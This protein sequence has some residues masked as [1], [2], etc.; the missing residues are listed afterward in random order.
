MIILELP[1]ELENRLNIEA[2]RLGVTQRGFIQQAI[3]A[4]LGDVEDME[5]A[6]IAEERLNVQGKRYT[7]DE[8]EKIIGLDS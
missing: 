7:L 5:D 2:Q 6:A 8:V 4:Y 3:I 1:N